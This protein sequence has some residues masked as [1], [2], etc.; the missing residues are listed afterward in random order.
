MDSS[1]GSRPSDKGGAQSSRSAL[2]IRVIIR[3]GQAPQ[4]TPLDLPL[5]SQCMYNFKTGS[6]KGKM[7]TDFSAK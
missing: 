3:G 7:A 2:I 6:T 1:G 4:A 5:N